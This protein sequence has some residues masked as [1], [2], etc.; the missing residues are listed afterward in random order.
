[1]RPLWPALA[2][3][4]LAAG[5]LSETKLQPLPSTPT[6]LA[7]R[8][9]AESHGV[10]LVAEPSVWKGRPSNLES[11]VTPVWV[12]LENQSGRPLRISHELFS[13]EGGSRFSYAALS[14]FEVR[15]EELAVGGSGLQGP[16]FSF[17][18]GLGWGWG[19]YPGLGYPWSPLLWSPPFYRPYWDPWW[20]SFHGFGPYPSYGYYPYYSTPV[21]ALPTRD[22][23]RRA[24]PQGTLE[25]GGIVSGFLYFQD[26]GGSERRVTLQ[27]R[28]VDARTG[29]PFGTLS[30]PFQVED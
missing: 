5:C 14:P 4:L 13:L 6:T 17:G 19:G 24:L 20:G 22:M 18:V 25:D 30:I 7:G 8:A 27:A 15:R 21:E 1:M 11:L 12:R 10:R 9:V 23:L 29:E 3:L 16:S 26:V 28:L 2:A